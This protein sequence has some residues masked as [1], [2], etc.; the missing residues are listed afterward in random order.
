MHSTRTFVIIVSNDK[1]SCRPHLEHKLRTL[2]PLKSLHVR[3]VA[4]LPLAIITSC[5]EQLNLLT[6]ASMIIARVDQIIVTSSLRVAGSVWPP[7][8]RTTK[9][10]SKLS[11][12]HL[13]QL[14]WDQTHTNTRI[15]HLEAHASNPA[16][17]FMPFNQYNP[18]DCIYLSTEGGNNAHWISK[19]KMA[20]T[21]VQW[22]L[23]GTDF[24]ENIANLWVSCYNGN[25]V[26]SARVLFVQHPREQG[27]WLRQNPRYARVLTASFALLPRVLDKQ[28]PRSPV[29]IP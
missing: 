11:L 28:H 26:R 27:E 14:I 1:V 7:V 17:Q 13:Q 16:G 5:L 23:S 4:W 6:K 2:L 25:D 29:I 18:R 20:A 9:L 22:E 12:T 3:T 8:C 15:E 10:S 21:A 19:K 24:R